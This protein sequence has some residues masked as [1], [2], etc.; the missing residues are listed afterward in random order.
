MKST[1]ILALSILISSF[2]A[3]VVQTDFYNTE[4]ESKKFFTVNDQF[5]IYDLYKPKLATQTNQM[6]LVIIVPGFQR[7]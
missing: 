1:L 6:P 3:S 5:I 4:I 2:F 7:S